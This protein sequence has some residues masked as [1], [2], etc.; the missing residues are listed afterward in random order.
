[1]LIDYYG[2]PTALQQLASVTAPEARLLVVQPYDR[3]AMPAIE[4]AIQRAELG[5]NP[6]ND[7]HLIRVPIPSLNEE[8]R[9]DYVRL[10]HKIAEESRVAIRNVRR[11]EMG[12]LKDLEK[13]HMISADEA[14]RAE[15]QLEKLTHKHVEEVEMLSARKEAEVLEV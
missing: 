6:S 11:D 4:K 14:K 15:E 5:L 12:T 1:L 8:R 2:T 9:R 3:S 13:E 10:V 7:G